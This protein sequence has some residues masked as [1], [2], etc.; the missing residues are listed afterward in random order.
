VKILKSA[1]RR[2]VR[3]GIQFLDKNVTGWWK[4]IRIS[5]LNMDNTGDCIGGQISGSYGK[6]LSDYR[7]TSRHAVWYGFTVPMLIPPNSRFTRYCQLL[8]EC[9]CEEIAKLRRAYLLSL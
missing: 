2:R 3:R 7:L 8:T 4:K 6:F 9:W 1:V 5:R